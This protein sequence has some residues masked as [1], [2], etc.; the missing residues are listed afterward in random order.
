MLHLNPFLF[1]L[2]IAWTIL[3]HRSV[4]YCYCWIDFFCPPSLYKIQSIFSVLVSLE[5]SNAKI[6]ESIFALWGAFVLGTVIGEISRLGCQF[7]QA[8]VRNL[9]KALFGTRSWKMLVS[10]GWHA[11]SYASVFWI[12]DS[13]QNRHRTPDNP[14]KCCCLFSAFV[15]ATKSQKDNGLYFFFEN[16]S[17]KWQRPFSKFVGKP[18]KRMATAS[19]SRNLTELQYFCVNSLNMAHY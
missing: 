3:L 9:R 5:V 1:L 7:C 11:S 15:S 8:G 10:P 4:I 19:R 16:M 12:S 2:C 18:S 6:V 17:K 14:P 13:S